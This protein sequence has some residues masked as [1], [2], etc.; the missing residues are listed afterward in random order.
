MKDRLLIIDLDE[1]II[2]SESFPG[3]DYLDKGSYD[4]SFSIDNEFIYTRKRPFLKE[5][6][7]YAFSNFKVAIWTA[8]DEVYANT[9]L[10]KC[11]IP[12]SELEFFWA[13]D[14]CTI[15]MDYN[16]NKYYGVKNLNKVRRSLNW[17]L[18]DVLIV[19]DIYA[20]AENNYGNLIKI[21]PFDFQ[22]NDSELLKLISYL[23][24]IK[25]QGDFRRIEKRGWSNRK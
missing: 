1:T 16:L 9:I 11:K 23:E 25:D 2:H 12:I 22:K 24:I 18:K 19:D 6:I 3:D 17:D 10:E 13:R 4:F 21:E 5:F 14:R 20:T 7:E 8:S 15:K